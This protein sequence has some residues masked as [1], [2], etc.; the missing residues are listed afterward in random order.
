MCL[1]VSCF[2]LCKQNSDCLLS[3][4]SSSITAVCFGRKAVNKINSNTKNKKWY[5]VRWYFC[6]ILGNV[7]V[8]AGQSDVEPNNNQSLG[9][10]I[11]QVPR[12]IL[13]RLAECFSAEKKSN[14]ECENI[15]V[16][17]CTINIYL[18]LSIIYQKHTILYQIYLITQIKPINRFP[19]FHGDFDF[20][21]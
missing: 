1:Y 6:T 5:R 4:V 17:Y 19:T 20:S 7:L 10:Y 15:T 18:S 16:Y 9:K 8:H 12:Q 21:T 11:T 13:S 3:V 2:C 14:G